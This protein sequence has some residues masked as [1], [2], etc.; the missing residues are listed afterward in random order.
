M[1][2]TMDTWLNIKLD[3][4]CSSSLP[5]KIL[6]CGLD[7]N[8]VVYLMFIR[9][10]VMLCVNISKG[11]FKCNTEEWT[12]DKRLN[13]EGDAKKKLYIWCSSALS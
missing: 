7:V 12:T 1:E 2:Y 5:W 4:W 11:N 6:I 13:L 10:M 3:I 8:K 9:Y